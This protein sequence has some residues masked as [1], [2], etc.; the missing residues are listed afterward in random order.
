MKL[1]TAVLNVAQVEQAKQLAA[2]YGQTFYIEDRCEL[3]TDFVFVYVYQA[4][5]FRGSVIVSTGW[6]QCHKKETHKAVEFFKIYE[7]EL[8]KI[9]CK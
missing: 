5:N 4:V 1:I 6:D 9:P 8:K 2:K 7:T 3:E